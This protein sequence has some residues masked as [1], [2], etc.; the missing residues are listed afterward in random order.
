M[1]RDISFYF[2]ADVKTVYNAYLAAASDARFRCSCNQQPYHTIS[3]SMNFSMKY[4]INGGSCTLHFIPYERGT[5]V[6]F[7]FA[8]VQL[9][10]A[11]YGSY[12][13]DLTIAAAA[14]INVTWKQVNVPIND[15]LDPRNQVS[16]AGTQAQPEYLPQPQQP[17]CLP[18]PQQPVQTPQPAAATRKCHACGGEL[19]ESAPFCHHCGA[20]RETAPKCCPQCG[21]PI[22]HT[23]TFCAQCGGRL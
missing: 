17:E 1:R 10:G 2:D 9:M 3:F 14:L 11:R 21:S 4:N 23:G 6:D 19:M 8:L 22:I 20:K 18:Q 15:F 12:A 5:A 16:A 13:Q 7:R